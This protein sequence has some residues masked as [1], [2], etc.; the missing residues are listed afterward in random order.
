MVV[1]CGPVDALRY[2]VQPIPAGAQGLIGVKY[3][4]R[5]RIQAFKKTGGFSIVEGIRA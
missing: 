3:L 4:E 5:K 1:A 2:T